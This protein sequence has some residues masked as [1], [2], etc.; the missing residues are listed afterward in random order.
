MTACEILR[1][2]SAAVIPF[3]AVANCCARSAGA[4]RVSSLRQ[5]AFDNAW[6]WIGVILVFAVAGEGTVANRLQPVLLERELRGVGR[7]ANISTTAS[8]ERPEIIVRPDLE[9]AA[10]RGVSAAAIGQVVRIATSGAFDANVARLNRPFPAPLAPIDHIYAAPAW[11]TRSR[12][13]SRTRSP[14][15]K[16]LLPTWRAKR[17]VMPARRQ[18][19]PRK[20]FPSKQPFFQ[21]PRSLKAA[22]RFCFE[23]SKK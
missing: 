10:E 9:R 7:L 19:T 8:L 12:Q 17:L 6:E 14:A 18:A 1:V 23:D 11:R 15:F 22:R 13:P 16:K 20:L 21:A 2:D 5:S 3:T 4:S